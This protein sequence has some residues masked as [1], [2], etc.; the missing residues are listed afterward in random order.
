[1]VQRELRRA[2]WK[3]IE[4]IVTPKEVVSFDF[5]LKMYSESMGK[6]KA[7]NNIQDGQNLHPT[8]ILRLTEALGIKPYLQKDKCDKYREPYSQ[9]IQGFSSGCK[10][11][12]PIYTIP[13]DVVCHVGELCTE[14]SCCTETEIIARSLEVKLIL[15]PCDFKLTVAI[16][17]LLFEVD[18]FHFEWGHQKQFDLYGVIEISF[19]L[20]N[21]Y[22][23]KKYLLNLNQSVYIQA[24]E[25]TSYVL[26][27]NYLLQKRPCEWKS[28]FFIEDFSLYQWMIN[29]HLTPDASLPSYILYRL[30]E[31]TNLAAYLE[32]Q[33]CQRVSPPYNG[34][35]SKECAFNMS[36]PNLSSLVACRI[37]ETCLGLTCCVKNEFLQ[38]TFQIYFELDPC[39]S[40]LS[41]GIEKAFYNTTLTD[42]KWGFDNYFSLQGIV[43]VMYNIEDLSTEKMYLITM[44]IMFCFESTSPECSENDQF[45]VLENTMLPKGVCDWSDHL[46]PSGFSLKQWYIEKGLAP[47]DTLPDW[48]ISHL[49]NQMRVS[50]YLNIQECR[51]SD[52]YN[53]QSING[54]KKDC[55]NTVALPKLDDPVSCLLS[56]ECTYIECC[57]DVH[58]IPRSFMF[59]LHIDPCEYQITVGIEKFFRNISLINYRWGITHDLWLV[60]IF[61]ASFNIR[62]F[63][64]ERMY[65]V[66]LNISICFEDEKPCYLTVQILQNTRLP[67]RLCS[68]ETKYYIEKFSLEKWKESKYIGKD[69]HLPAYGLSLLFEE[70]GIS[71]FL[72]KEQCSAE[73]T[74]YRKNLP[75]KDDCPLKRPSEINTNAP[76]YIPY[77]CTGIE[78]CVHADALRRDFE[79]TVILDS[80]QFVFTIGIETFMR[81][82]S[83]ATLE[84]E[85]GYIKGKNQ[86]K[87]VNA[88]VGN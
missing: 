83:V 54:W 50:S 61:H 76:C 79:V 52:I 70:I 13:Q 67:R 7:D 18:L 42:F 23:E 86:Q 87:R 30:Y 77:L 9:N 14:I 43:R 29:R 72:R 49:L 41:I 56:S 66:S 37:F 58:F 62:S 84:L 59:Y 27:E 82:L 12:L 5:L 80:C 78:C 74:K 46:S 64:G 73:I 88:F 8:E 71:P 25:P 21:L 57:V 6:W 33:M 65:V 38:R 28:D 53:S 44:K 19:S 11:V 85:E 63:P 47:T 15:D 3:Y 20:E 2:Y 4:N 17:R 36:L 60:G 40:K 24:D 1:M 51:R 22:E 48:M 10:K 75:I 55:S 35:W 39:S 31:E 69:Q 68:W 26:F 34:E 32:D 16:E 81:N 45:T